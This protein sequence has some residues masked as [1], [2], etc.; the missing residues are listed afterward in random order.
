MQ[1]TCNAS[2]FF[3]FFLS[4]TI[5]FNITKDDN[6]IFT[7]TKKHNK[8]NQ[9][10]LKKATKKYDDEDEDVLTLAPFHVIRRIRRD[11]A[12]V[13]EKMQF[14]LKRMK[15]REDDK[16]YHEYMSRAATVYSFGGLPH[17]EATVGCNCS[18]AYHNR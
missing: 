3:F 13:L 12:D 10:F 1:S 9:Q 5:F 6:F 16:R 8:N 14:L 2:I 17:T 7:E 11:E 4:F 15:E 18:N